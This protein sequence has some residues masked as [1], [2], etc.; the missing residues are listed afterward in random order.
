MSSRSYVPV[1]NS[2]ETARAANLLTRRLIESRLCPLD[3][4]G[5]LLLTSAQLVDRSA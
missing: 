4:V 3:L 1:T 5:M 2:T